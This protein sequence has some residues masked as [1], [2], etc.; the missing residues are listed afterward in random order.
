[1]EANHVFAGL[2]VAEIDGAVDWYSRLFGRGPDI[3]PNGYEA[4]WRLAPSASL[5]VLADPAR[6]G[7][8]AATVAVADLDA[9]VGTLPA[10]GIEPGP[11]EQVHVGARKAEVVDPDGNTIALIEVRAGP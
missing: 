1:V 2:V 4:I 7:H 3:V 5:Y 6:A 10:R 11:V 9:L 8:G